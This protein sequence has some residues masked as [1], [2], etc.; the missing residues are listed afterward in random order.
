MYVL[1]GHNKKSKNALELVDVRG[2][3]QVPDRV[4]VLDG[5]VRPFLV[6][7]K[8]KKLSRLEPEL[9]FRCTQSNLVF[10]A[11]SQ[12]YCEVV[13]KLVQIVCIPDPVVHVISVPPLI[14]FAGCCAIRA[15]SFGATVSL[16]KGKRGGLNEANGGPHGN[17]L[18]CV[19]YPG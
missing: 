16:A 8:A 3:H 19:M 12:E 14:H 17:S 4:K 15:L 10:A 13:I 11:D 6:H 7:P 5:K 2:W 9:G 1:P 18:S